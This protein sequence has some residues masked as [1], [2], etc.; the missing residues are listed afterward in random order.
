MLPDYPILTHDVNVKVLEGEILTNIDI[1][2]D[3]R[4]MLLTTKS[5]R[6]FRFHHKQDCCEDVKI[7]GLDE[8]F[9]T[10]QGK[11]INEVKEEVV[12]EE[13]M[14]DYEHRTKTNFIFK[15]DENTAICRWV[16]ISNGY[17]SET[18]DIDELESAFK[19]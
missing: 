10:L 16:G 1:D 8:N 13:N 9:T 6:V 11:V 18:V 7:V 4:Q 15:T 3:K 17:Y 2:E 19:M 14:E 5:G 12:E